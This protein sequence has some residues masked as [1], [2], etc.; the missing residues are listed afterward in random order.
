MTVKTTTTAK[1]IRI[2]CQYIDYRQLQRY[3]IF[4]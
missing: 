1:V 2:S 4:V 3:F